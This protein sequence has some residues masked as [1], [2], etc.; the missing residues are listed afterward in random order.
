MTNDIAVKWEYLVG[1]IG[2]NG[3]VLI[4]DSDG[5]DLK[6]FKQLGAEGWELVAII[7]SNTAYGYVMDNSTEI[8]NRAYFKRS[9]PSDDGGGD[10]KYAR[11]KGIIQNAFTKR[12]FTDGTIADLLA[13]QLAMSEDAAY[14]GEADLNEAERTYL[15]QFLDANATIET[16]FE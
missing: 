14:L 2:V 12:G 3:L 15:K 6:H 13:L 9:L 5:T 16:I 7:Q 1:K 10:D 11:I 8:V 4:G